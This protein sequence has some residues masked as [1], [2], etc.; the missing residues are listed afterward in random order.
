MDE[1]ENR[2]AWTIR[3]GRSGNT[4]ILKFYTLNNLFPKYIKQSM[5]WKE[6]QWTNSPLELEILRHLT[7]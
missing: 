1:K 6:K 7:Q 4:V 3:I 5:N 2:K